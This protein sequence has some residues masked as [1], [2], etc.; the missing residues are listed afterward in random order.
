MPPDPR[1]AAAILDADLLRIDAALK[2]A[3]RQAGLMLRGRTQPTRWYEMGLRDR[4]V[5][6]P[7]TTPP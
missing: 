4:L 1:P 3:G 6:R 7:R 5:G 2:A